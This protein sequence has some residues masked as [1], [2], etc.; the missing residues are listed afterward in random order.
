MNT[1]EFKK[2]YPQYSHLTGDNLWDKMTE[3]FCQDNETYTADPDRDIIYHKPV[4]L[5]NG[6]T[7][8]LEDSSKT[9]WINSKG[10]KGYLKEKPKKGYP[11]ES[12]RMTILDLSK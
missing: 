4:I 3:L 7:V 11:T 6:I 10:Q 1:K 2:N 9:V 12:Y 8:K 5:N